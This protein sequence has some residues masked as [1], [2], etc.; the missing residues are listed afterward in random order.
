MTN[1]K[2]TKMKGEERDN[3][4]LPFVNT[5]SPVSSLCLV[6]FLFTLW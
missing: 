6:W 2:K 3:V 1:N 4:L 5:L